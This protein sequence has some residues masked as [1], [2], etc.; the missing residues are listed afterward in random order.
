MT[1][2]LQPPALWTEPLFAPLG[3]IDLRVVAPGTV[4]RHPV[5]GEEATVDDGNVV[6][7][8]R[9]MYLTPTMD[10]A[11]ADHPEVRTLRR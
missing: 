11:L 6:M 5:S 3:A 9:V 1:D 10:Q 2:F 7:I 4:V 8:G